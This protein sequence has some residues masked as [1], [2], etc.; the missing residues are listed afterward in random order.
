EGVAALAFGRSFSCGPGIIS[1]FPE[2]GSI[3]A[4]TPLLTNGKRLLDVGS[5]YPG[6]FL[7]R[8]RPEVIV[9]PEIVDAP[10]S[11][12]MPLTQTEALTQLIAQGIGLLAERQTVVGQLR[13]FQELV[14]QARGF[15]L[16]CGAD[17]HSKPGRLAALLTE[18]LD[19]CIQPPIPRIK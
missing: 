9:F 15:R 17:V 10:V 6:Q 2:L 19:G 4:N 16:L 5:L 3:V 18:T 8:C 1:H 12:L 13:L 7:P 14:K 11:R